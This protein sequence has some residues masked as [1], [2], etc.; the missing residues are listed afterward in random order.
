MTDPVMNGLTIIRNSELASKK[1]C[2]VKP[3]SKFFGE[4]LKIAKNNGYIADYKLIEEHQKISYKVN[5]NGKLNTIKAIKPRYA[6]K[7]DEFEKYEKRY[8]PAR[9]VG[10][11]VV[12]TSQGVLTHTEAKAK[13]LGGR[14]IAF[15]Y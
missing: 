5:L 1:E 6:V 8:L 14:L 2:E 12:S 9:D 3:A 15:M 4:I 10:L 11:I 13:K 7:R